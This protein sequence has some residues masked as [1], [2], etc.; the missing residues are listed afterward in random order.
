MS[1]RK[2]R[3]Y[4]DIPT[5][6]GPDVTMNQTITN[7]SLSGCLVIT[8]TQ[9]NVGSTLSLSI[10]VS[11]GKLLRLKGRVVREHRQDGYGIGFEE[12]PDKDRRELALLIAETDERELT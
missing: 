7:I 9:L 5:H 4:V 2:I 6:L 1:E 10:P 8:G 3:A 11:G 12:M